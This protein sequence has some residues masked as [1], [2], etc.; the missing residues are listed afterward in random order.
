MMLKAIIQGRNIRKATSI[1]SSMVCLFAAST[2]FGQIGWTLE[3]CEKD[4]GQP[5]GHKPPSASNDVDEYDFESWGYAIS[6]NFL[7]GKVQA[8]TYARLDDQP[9]TTNEV[10]VLL[11]KNSKDWP[12]A[13]PT[14]RHGPNG[15][16]FYDY[17]TVG[18]NRGKGLSAEFA[19][20]Y[21]ILTINAL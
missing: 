12:W 2:S 7:D 3:Q 14:L 8:I 11:M 16:D 17:M 1:L 20:K 18:A 13:K 10:K 4:Y 6:C 19:L 9:L 21:G 15:R 5:T